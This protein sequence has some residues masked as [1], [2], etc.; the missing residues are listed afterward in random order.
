MCMAVRHGPKRRGALRPSREIFMDKGCANQTVL[1]L[2]RAMCAIM[3]KH[4]LNALLCHRCSLNADLATDTPQSD[5]MA[6][7]QLAG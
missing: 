7:A 5:Q 4:E 3:G 2:V 6:Q 1:T